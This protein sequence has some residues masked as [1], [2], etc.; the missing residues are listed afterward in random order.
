MIHIGG[1]HAGL[2]Q[3]PANGFGRETGPVFD[4]IKAFFFHS[5]DQLAV[6]NQSGRGIAVIRV[7]SQ[8]IHVLFFI[9]SSWCRVAA[10]V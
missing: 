10:G 6:D 1:I 8:D 4:T 9:V 7:D 5:G 2:I 3:A